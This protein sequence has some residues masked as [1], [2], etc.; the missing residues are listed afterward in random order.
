MALEVDPLYDKN[1]NFVGW[2]VDFSFVYNKD[3]AW[4][5]YIF[6]DFVWSVRTRKWIGELRGTNLLDRDGRIVAWSTSGPVVGN[7]DI[8]EAPLDIEPPIMPPMPIIDDIPLNPGS[9]PEPSGEW[10]RLTFNQWLN[11]R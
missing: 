8:I 9:A 2:L 3:L 10:S 7:I 5:A 1:A 4:V 11:Q 6:N